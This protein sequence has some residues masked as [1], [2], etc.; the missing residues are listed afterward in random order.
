M[1][2]I[3]LNAGLVAGVALAALPVILHLFMKQR[4]KKVIFPALRLIRERQKQ[5]RKTLK[6]KNWLL[7]AARMALIALMALALARPRIQVDAKVRAGSGEAETAIGLVFDTSLSMGYTEQDKSRLDIAKDRAEDLLKKA[8]SGSQVYVID[9]AEPAVPAG[10]S[11]AA[12]RKRIESLTIRPGNRP[13]NQAVGVAYAAVAESPKERREV[14]VFTDLAKSS[15]RTD[16]AVDGLDKVKAAPGGIDTFVVRVSPKDRHDVSIVSIEPTSGL[17]SQD[18]PVPIRVRL[19]AVGK[20]A[21]RVVEFYVDGQKKDQKPVEVP[22]DDEVDVPAYS[23]KLG[24]GLHRVEVRLSGEPDPLKFDDV[25]YLTLDVKPS[26]RVLIVS[27][28]N[29]DADYV[30]QALDPDALRERPGLPRPF[31]VDRLV[32]GSLPPSGF[33]KPLKEY[34]AVFLLNIAELKPGQWRELGEFVK[35]GGGLVLGAGDRMAARAELY[36]TGDGKDLMPAALGAVKVHE[37]FTFGRA[38]VTDALFAQNSRELLAALAAVPVYKSLAAQPAADSRTLLSYQDDTPALIERLVGAG[39][40]PGR[41]LLWT[42]ALH[43]VPETTATWTEFPIANWSFYHLMN[44]TIP[45]LAGTAGRKLVVEAGE[46][47]T[48]PIEPGKG[49]TDFF[50]VPPQAAGSGAPEPIRLTDAAGNALAIP[51]LTMA[52]SGRDPVGHWTVNAAKAGGGKGTFG[53][54]VNPPTDE[55]RLDLLETKELD[56]LF[57]K[58]AY[59]LADDPST[60]EQAVTVTR[61]GRELTPWIM[62]L[63][64]LLVTAENALA[65]LFYRENPAASAAGRPAA[66]GAA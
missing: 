6:L 57:G 35:Q 24:T 3:F 33:P 37:E 40:A 28:L 32:T 50:A 61:L 18:E 66:R 13:L 15:W 23:P 12:A 55:T 65:N 34:A 42:T 1:S 38:D 26:M 20:P 11:P 21:S 51:A 56:G 58:D 45:Y 36:N 22:A 64:L 4:P 48:L 10:L 14:Y 62:L 54:S 19:K 47:V 29:D 41:V 25:A 31:Q 39:A 2:S 53:F 46:G 9:T 52:A 17:A 30:A 8:H 5:S 59:K 60:L 63:I 49:Y 27:D 44:Q 16:Q 7:L 43:R